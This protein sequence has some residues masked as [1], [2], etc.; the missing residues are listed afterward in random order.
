MLEEKKPVDIGHLNVMQNAFDKV[1]HKR[2]LTKLRGYGINDKLLDWIKDF[3][4][5]R[6]QHVNIGG[7][8]LE[9]VAVMSGV[10]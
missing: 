1:H 6:T 9:D 3:L 8:C 4:M 5:D 7:E 10:P 2:L